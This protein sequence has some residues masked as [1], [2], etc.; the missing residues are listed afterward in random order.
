[1]LNELGTF[2]NSLLGRL[3]EFAFAL[4]A[5]SVIFLFYGSNIAAFAQ[6]EDDKLPSS[7]VLAAL[8]LS[9]VS[10]A[11]LIQQLASYC[12][13]YFKEVKTKRSKNIKYQLKL[14]QKID[15]L[16]WLNEYES[17]ILFNCLQ[18]YEQTFNCVYTKAAAMSLLNK[19]VIESK[20]QGDMMNMPF[21]ISNDVW[22]KLISER[23]FWLEKLSEKNKKKKP[24]RNR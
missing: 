13:N 12:F 5:C 22:K 9:F 20:T 2:F 10:G 4:F 14:Q 7:L 18:N 23:E 1:M 19:G 17:Q 21:T 16:Q 8:A 15:S 3:K 6:L 11:T 24:C